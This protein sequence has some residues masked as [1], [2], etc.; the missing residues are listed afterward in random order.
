MDFL[1]DLKDKA[2]NLTQMGVSKSKHLVEVAK[3]KMSTM[4]ETETIRKA[5]QDMG[6]LYYAERGMSPEPAYV[7]LCEKV[8]ASRDVIRHNNE[9]LLVLKNEGVVV[10]DDDVAE[11]DVEAEDFSDFADFEDVEDIDPP[12]QTTEEEAE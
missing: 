12:A 9:A 10:D 5:Y 8:K 11:A 4:S 6:K 3:L 1:E 2:Q 7:A